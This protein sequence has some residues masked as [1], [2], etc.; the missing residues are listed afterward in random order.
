MTE[1]KGRP[2]VRLL[3]AALSA[4]LA[5]WPALA[6]VPE[7]I[8]YQGYLRETGGI[9]TGARTMVFRLYA[10]S[11]A[12]TPLWTSPE[13]DVLVSTGLFHVVLE[14]AGIDWENGAWLEVEI[15]GTRLSPREELLAAPYAIDAQR[16]SGRRFAT[17]PV[18]PSTA[19]AGDL[20]YE[21]SAGEL[22]F[23]NGS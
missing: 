17:G 16:L 9:A 2:A 5:A 3:A 8:S 13:A 4:W 14:P 18:A 22:R 10:S 6:A 1:R 7:R 20:W 12:Q 11:A 19:A 23:F 15:N 21:T